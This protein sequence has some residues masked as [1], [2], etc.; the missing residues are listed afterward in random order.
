M[1]H[2]RHF[3]AFTVARLVA[4]WAGYAHEKKLA[5]ERY[6]LSPPSPLSVYLVRRTEQARSPIMEACPMKRISRITAQAIDLG[7]VPGS[8]TSTPRCSPGVV[9]P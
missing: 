7:I 1:S 3:W 9:N 2:D 6:P 5:L 4:L 8:C